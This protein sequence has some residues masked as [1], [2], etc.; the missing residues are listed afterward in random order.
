[1]IW[2]SAHDAAKGYAVDFLS[3]GVHALSRDLEAF[4][5]ECI[6]MQ[7]RRVLPSFCPSLGFRA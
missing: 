4:P 6:Y 3:L 7:V 1:M 2:L 5:R